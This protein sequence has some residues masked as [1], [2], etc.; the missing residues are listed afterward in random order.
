VSEVIPVGRGPLYPCGINVRKQMGC[1]IGAPRCDS[2][3]AYRV[4]LAALRLAALALT[5]KGWMERFSHSRTARGRAGG[6]AGGREGGEGREGSVGARSRAVFKRA[7]GRDFSKR[8]SASTLQR[9]RHDACDSRGAAWGVRRCS[10]HGGASFGR[11]RRPQPCRGM[12][13]ATGVAM[14]ASITASTPTG[15]YAERRVRDQCVRI[16]CLEGTEDRCGPTATRAVPRERRRARQCRHI[17][18]PLDYRYS[19]AKST[20][21]AVLTVPTSGR[22]PPA[23][24]RLPEAARAASPRTSAGSPACLGSGGARYGRFVVSQGCSKYSAVPT[25][26]T[27]LH[28]RTHT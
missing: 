15:A 2:T 11:P 10:G 13:A 28:A 7:Y 18:V 12:M 8:S 4:R 23:R 16:P 14:A 1:R 17:R 22:A 6:R 25:Q 24:R 9:R 21:G 3:R 26:P 5:G 19:T 27:E 20:T